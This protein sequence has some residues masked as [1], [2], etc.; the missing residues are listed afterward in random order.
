[1]KS[2]K[3]FDFLA[4]HLFMVF[5][6]AAATVY[7]FSGLEVIKPEHMS[8][9]K[10]SLIPYVF[11][12]AF[13]LSFCFALLKANRSSQGVY[14]DFFKAPIDALL[15]EAESNNPEESLEQ[16]S[17][18]NQARET[19]R[20]RI[21]VAQDKMQNKFYHIFSKQTVAA[22]FCFA[23]AFYPSVLLAQAMSNLFGPGMS[24]VMLI[25][26][27]LVFFKTISD[28]S[29]AKEILNNFTGEAEEIPDRL[30]TGTT[31]ADLINKVL[32]T[33]KLSNADM[34]DTPLE[35]K[36]KDVISKEEASKYKK[37]KGENQD[38]NSQDQE[39]ICTI[40]QESP[41][42][43]VTFVFAPQSKTGDVVTRIHDTEALKDWFKRCERE[44][45]PIDLPERLPLESLTHCYLGWPSEQEQKEKNIFPEDSDRKAK[46]KKIVFRHVHAGIVPAFLSLALA[47]LIFCFQ[48]DLLPYNVFLPALFSCA[49]LAPLFQLLVQ[50]KNSAPGYDHEETLG[51]PT[52]FSEGINTI[53]LSRQDAEVVLGNVSE[54]LTS[55]PVVLPMRLNGSVRLNAISLED[56]IKHGLNSRDFPLS[57]TSLLG[58]PDVGGGADARSN[59]VSGIQPHNLRGG[60]GGG[61]TA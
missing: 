45:H 59:R 40:T 52:L 9:L 46:A 2:N 22:L 47:S 58:D 19:I 13:C 41:Q 31:P 21:E 34:R 35:Q 1:M 11:L 36:V 61:C 20:E 49:I 51:I 33:V 50:P 43:P 60:G 3:A 10:N 38:G 29:K 55:S 56:L 12:G 53:H 30:Y 18:L 39:K 8:F 6:V 17:K 54:E 4:R 32:L 23:V 7:G 48:R 5:F 57:H 26:A 44:G 16:N 24:W 37:N 25:T 14:Q 42:C 15:A 27:S 28:A